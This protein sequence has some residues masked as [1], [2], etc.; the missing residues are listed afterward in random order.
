[1][2]SLKDALL[3]LLERFHNPELVGS[4]LVIYVLVSPP[5]RFG[6]VEGCSRADRDQ[7]RI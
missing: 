1:M 5:L 6:E 3:Q 2:S 7:P 4:I